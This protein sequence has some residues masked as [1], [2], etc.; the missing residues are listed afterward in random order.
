MHDVKPHVVLE[1]CPELILRLD[2]LL[3]AL[4]GGMLKE[5]DVGP[6]VQH[7]PASRNAARMRERGGGGGRPAERQRGARQHLAGSAGPRM[8]Q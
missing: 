6:L 7:R 8:R 4:L 1:H 3:L 5:K 2:I